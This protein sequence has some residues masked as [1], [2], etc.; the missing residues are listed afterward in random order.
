MVG[1]RAHN[2]LLIYFFSRLAELCTVNL[3]ALLPFNLSVFCLTT[4][5]ALGEYGRVNLF[6]LEFSSPFKLDVSP[7]DS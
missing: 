6:H 2:Y 1:D 4:V 3:T 5:L 7:Y